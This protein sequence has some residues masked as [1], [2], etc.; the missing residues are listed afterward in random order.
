MSLTALQEQRGR[1]V[2]QAREALDEIK[3]NTDESRAAELDQRHDAIMAE[4]DKVEANIAREE[5]LAKIEGESREAEERARE[6]RRPGANGEQRGSDDGDK[7]DYRTAFAQWLAAGGDKSEMSAE[8]RSVLAGGF[9]KPEERAQTTSNTAGGYTIPTEVMPELVKSMLA[10]GPMYDPGV[11]RE[12]VTSSGNPLTFPTVNDTAVT[13][14]A[15]G[16]EAVTL[17][18]DGGKDATFGQKTLG[19]YA[20]DTEWLRVSKELADDSIFNMESVLADLLG[21]RLGRIANLN[22]TTGNGSTAPNGIVTAAA[23]ATAAA[24]TSA[25]TYDEILNF[26]HSVDP[27]YRTGPKVRYMMH[28]T[29]LLAIRKLK[30]GDGNYLWQMGNVQQGVPNVI[31]GRPYSINQA[32]ANVGSG[33]GSKVLLFGDFGKYVVRK[34]G[35]ILIGAIQDK[36]FWPG[37]G[38]AGYIRFDGE[39]LD[40]A[41]VKSLPLAAS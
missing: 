19:A 5:R 10:W 4:F 9:H 25:I 29:T 3:S 30:D 26:E 11:T 18:D 14:G 33:A 28:D 39:L 2:T 22:L 8:A 38:I 20:F 36:D 6:Q 15:S 7:V 41:A 32:M 27:A 1:L 12:M 21:E 23:A 34:V 17:T 35:G 24:S 31:N 16:G 13:A 37:F 40:T